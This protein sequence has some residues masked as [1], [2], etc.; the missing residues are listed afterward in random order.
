[1]DE[2]SATISRMVGDL[3]GTEHTQVAP[4]LTAQW[5]T[6]TRVAVRWTHQGWEPVEKE[7]KEEEEE[8]KTTWD[9]SGLLGH[10]TSSSVTQE[11][12]SEKV[13]GTDGQKEDEAKK[14]KKKKPAAVDWKTD[15]DK[16]H[17]EVTR[18]H[19]RAAL[20]MD[21]TSA[22]VDLDVNYRKKGLLWFSTYGV[23]FR[24]VYTVRNPT[25]HEI[26]VTMRFAYPAANA[27]YD[28]MKVTVAGNERGRVSAETESMVAHFPVAPGATQ[29]VAFGYHS[30]GMD[31]WNYSFGPD[32]KMVRNFDLV[33]RTDFDDYDF[34]RGSISPDTKTPLEDGSGWELGWDKESVVSGKSIGMIMPERI[35]PGP[36]AQGMTLHAPVSLFFFF[37]V[38]FVLQMHRSIK[39]HP[40][41]YFFI[42]AGFFAFNL[43][44][45]Y[46][47]DHLDVFLA[48]GIAA[49]VSLLL[50]TS[51][52]RLV[53]GL[54]FAFLEAGISQV[55]YQ[56]L[57]GLAHFMDGY[58]GLTITVGAIIT[59][60]I[61]MQITGRTDW[62]R[63][64]R[65][66]QQ[67]ALDA[68]AQAE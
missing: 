17:Y 14:K 64:F 68:P 44:F 46:L 41:N 16:R 34:P 66:R 33:M 6:E 32:V 8:E 2:R 30:R 5:T 3:W 13:E 49:A 51:Y 20:M 22:E 53:V 56:A 36:L 37:F 12:V 61:V 10:V 25:G 35:N 42:A 47:V 50:V 11:I 18:T 40:M 38:M 55:I 54:R 63:V 45:S 60:A 48:F 7:G 27:I 1:T 57:F 19:H 9:R 62:A 43:L 28:N 24:S 26:D 15:P 31:Q 39:M 21:G 59:L 52:L 65:G 4:E 67:V 29:E 58:T 23:G